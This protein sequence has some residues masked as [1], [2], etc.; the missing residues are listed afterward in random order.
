MRADRRKLQ[1]PVARPSPR[2]PGQKIDICLAPAAWPSQKADD[3]CPLSSTR[4]TVHVDRP[5]RSPRGTPIRACHLLRT[6][7]RPREASK[8]RQ[9]LGKLRPCR[10]LL[11]SSGGAGAAKWASYPRR[12]GG[13]GGG[14]AGQ[15]RRPRRV[16]IRARGGK[17]RGRGRRPRR[18]G[19]APRSRAA[20][21]P[22]APRSSP[23]RPAAAPGPRGTPSQLDAAPGRA[24]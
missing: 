10:S 4:T 22:R 11:R 2:G 15:R 23:R 18:R 1:D 7:T 13:R 6:G 19:L 24:S 14:A 8:W 12:A 5:P 20:R 3:G 16:H 17:G 9:P 21:S